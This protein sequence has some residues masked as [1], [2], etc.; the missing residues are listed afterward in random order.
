MP[1]NTAY[2]LVDFGGGARLERFGDRLVDRPHPAALG[3]RR[4]P[5]AWLD[6]DLRYDRD[7][8]W[9]GSASGDM[10]WPI[11]LAGLTLELRPTDSG[12]VGIFPEH[13]SSL[14]WLIAQ[15][16]AADSTRDGTQAE[17]A[18]PAVLH[19]FGY[20]G[21]ITLALAASGA[22]VTHVD[23]ARPTVAWARRNAAASTLEDRPIRWIVDDA[24]A[25]TTREARRGR[26]YA[27]VV[28]DPPTYGHGPAGRSWRIDEDLPQ[29]LE[30]VA[31]VLEPDGFIML[32]AHSPGFDGDHLAS[33]LTDAIP[34]RS[35]KPERGGLDLSSVD[36]RRLDLGAFAR[37]PRG[38]S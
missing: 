1:T 2:D 24:L 25:F 17:V 6:A 8:G 19:L 33:A 9:T 29:L 22:A 16:H 26:T 36:G 28:L 11:Q 5:A 15:L 4:D 34:R 38:A 30:A 18:A 20:T 10:A 14:P 31:G 32:T 3:S 7:G 27:G 37:W 21:L 13:L 12:Q 35:R 23:S